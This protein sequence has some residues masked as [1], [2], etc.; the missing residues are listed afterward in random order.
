[1]PVAP[2][3]AAVGTAKG[4]SNTTNT[5][6]PAPSGVVHGQLVY[7]FMYMEANITIT[8][9]DTDFVELTSYPVTTGTVVVERVW[10]KRSVATSAEAGPYVFNHALAF[11]E[12]V[13]VRLNGA[14]LGATPNETPNNAQRSSNSTTTPGVS[15]T[16]V[17]PDVLLVHSSASVGAGD[18]T[19]PTQGGTWTEHFDG[20]ELAVSS[21][22]QATPGATGSVTQTAPNGFQLAWLIPVIPNQEPGRMVMAAA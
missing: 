5:S 14:I 10:R 17:N 21:K 15:L 13:A 16:T 19:P 7:V 4:P 3:V 18:F 20:S 8:P 12:A 1:M 6:V 9:V 2:D 22:A 11:S